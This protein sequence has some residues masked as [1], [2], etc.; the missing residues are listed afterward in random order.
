[1]KCIEDIIVAH[2]N[3]EA[4]ADEVRRLFEWIREEPEN[5]REFARCSLL[6]AQLRGQLSGEK[7]AR[8]SGE[9]PVVRRSSTSV[10][11]GTS[12]RNWKSATL[13]LA[14]CALF[15]VGLSLWLHDGD[16][17]ITQQLIGGKSFVT[18][19]QMV[20]AEWGSNANL[21]KGDRLAAQTLRLRR[22]ILRLLFDDGVEVTLQGPAHYELVAPGDTKL[23]SGLLAA[24]V[25]PGAKGFRVETPTA[26]V[27]V[28]GTA[29]GIALDDQG[30]A[31]VSVFDGEVEVSSM[32]NGITKL[33]KEGEAVRVTNNK[34]IEPARFD[35]SAYE[36]LW[37]ISSGI[38]RSTGAFRFSPPWPRRLRFVRSDDDIFVVPEGYVTTLVEPLRVNITSPGKYVRAENL[39][40]S[41]IPAGRPVRSFI[42]HFHPNH[43]G[44]RQRFE[45]T[46]GSI[47]FD[48]PVLGLIVLHKELAASAE[49]FPGRKAGEF[50][51]HRQLELTGN[52]VGDVITLSDNRRTV[53]LDVAA[54]GR[55]S[56]LVRVIVNASVEALANSD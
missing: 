46:T 29:F 45:R 41:E 1:M 56:D 10:E 43:D 9:I 55:F 21:N 30:V 11:A 14:A 32:G 35:T 18:I 15:V 3:D 22:G 50:L 34:E 40:P 2:L 24:T 12:R 39:T 49:R 6:H 26:E 13:A 53:S 7:R 17:P 38:E 51:E 37:P 25:P 44:D 20:D 28:L 8:E 31:N 27:V 36:K 52:R 33:L 4:S 48:R 16:E 47:T 42:L 23:M 5:A 19:E 54:P